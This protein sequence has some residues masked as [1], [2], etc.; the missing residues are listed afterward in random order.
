M[1]RF[2][3][4]AAV[5][6]PIAAAVVVPGASFGSS[7]GT[8][9]S[10][11]HVRLQIREALVKPHLLAPRRFAAPRLRG[12]AVQG[13]TLTISTGRWASR[14]DCNKRAARCRTITEAAKRSYTPGANDVGYVIMR[15]VIA[16]N[17]A[18][19]TTATAAPSALITA[20]VVT[21]WS[22]TGA[23]RCRR[24]PARCQPQAPVST[25]SPVI[26][27]TAQQGDTLSVS[28]GGWSGSPAGFG[29]AWA[30]CDSNGLN[31]VPISGADKNTYTLQAG[32]VG[33]TIEA[34]VTATNAGGSTTA[35]TTPTAVVTAATPPAPV[36]T[37]SPVI[38]GTAQ[39]GDTL[40]VSDGAWSGSPAG[41]GYAW[42]DCD[43]N[44][45]NCV[46]ISGAG[47]NTYT[48]QAS[49]VGE[50]IE[51]SVTATNAGGSTTATTTPTA[52]VTAAT[53]PAPVST[54]SPVISGTAQQGDTLSVSDGAWS[55]SPAGFGYAWQ[56]C[57]SNGLN[58]VPISGA[59]KNTY[60][61][62]AS[63]VGEHDRGV[64]D[65]DQRGW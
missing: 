4:I 58:C 14:Q 21:R 65:R 43:T 27:G 49:D 51:A 54:T 30:D 64:G 63:D 22:G 10:T 34:S 36:S 8:S 9:G 18:S 55:G 17:A 29:Y 53:P 59:D 33:E 28:D 1:R 52:V 35:T 50:T 32:D 3:S 20:A 62:Q 38:S 12:T 25:A 19:S 15:Q 41:F 5:V 2:T 39:Q 60:T 48:L 42:A 11:G 37:T 61:L 40:S 57:D 6:L 23:G 44:G 47:K 56:D 24:R 26:S 45:L 16:I 31:C 13:G 7:F 46:P